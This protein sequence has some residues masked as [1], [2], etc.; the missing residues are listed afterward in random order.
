MDVF[1]SVLDFISSV[2][3]NLAFKGVQKDEYSTNDSSN[4]NSTYLNDEKKK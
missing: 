3:G 1:T 2:L 4:D